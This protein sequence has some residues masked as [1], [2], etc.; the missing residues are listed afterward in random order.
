M[1]DD[2]QKPRRLLDAVRAA[3]RVRHY[4]YRTDEAYVYWVRYFVRFHGRRHPRE[5]H[6]EDEGAFLSWLSNERYVSAA[7]QDQ[8]LNAIAFLYRAVLDRPLAKVPKIAPL[9]CHA[10]AQAWHGYPHRTGTA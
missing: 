1:N 8:A 7:T 2:T 5:L 3:V 10:L 4:N 6:E 9:L